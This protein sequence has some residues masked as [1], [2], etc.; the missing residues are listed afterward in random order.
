MFE[1]YT[2]KA[3]RMVFFARY[4]ASES[5]SPSIEPHHLLL[6]VARADVTWIE[7]I[8][9]SHAGVDALRQRFAPKA[10]TPKV[11]TSA[12]LPL[13]RESRRILTHAEEESQTLEHREVGI[14]HLLI[15]IVHEKG[16]VAAEILRGA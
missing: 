6:G 14:E 4:E 8:F 9:G 12:D 3:R 5:A 15:G 2:E 16:T 13:S 1:R 10:G 11:S 7:R